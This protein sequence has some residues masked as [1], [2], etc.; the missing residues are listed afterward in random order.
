MDC[1]DLPLSIV[2]LSLWNEYIKWS[3]QV[4]Q[5]LTYESFVRIVSGWVGISC[6]CFLSLNSKSEHMTMMH[7]EQGT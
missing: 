2:Q 6:A 1:M 4:C 3:L 7:T 5:Y